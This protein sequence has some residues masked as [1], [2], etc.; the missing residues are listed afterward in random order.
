MK[1]L[2]G[3]MCY[4]LVFLLVG[5]VAMTSDYSGMGP[6]HRAALAGPPVHDIFSDCMSL[7]YI[8]TNLA[9]ADTFWFNAGRTVTW[10]AQ[11]ADYFGPS[12]TTTGIN[13]SNGTKIVGMRPVKKALLYSISPF[14]VQVWSGG[15]SSAENNYS[16]VDTL[17]V[18]LPRAGDKYPCWTIA[19]YPDSL[20]FKTAGDSVSMILGY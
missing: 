3:F 9:T 2:V 18:T 10:P 13:P 1:R 17:A 11:A 16:L 14:S 15:N 6:H 12:S 20:F 5:L 8:P 19:M 4:G 7:E